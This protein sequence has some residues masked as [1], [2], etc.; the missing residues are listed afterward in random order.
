[1]I[2]HVTWRTFFFLGGGGGLLAAGF[3]AWSNQ[4][5]PSDDRLSLSLSLSL[6]F[7]L[8]SSPSP[9]FVFSIF[10]FL[11]FF[12]AIFFF[13]RFLGGQSQ[14]T[15]T[16]KKEPV[17]RGD[18]IGDA[19]DFTAATTGSS[20]RRNHW[21]E[22]CVFCWFV[23]FVKYSLSRMT[24]Q[25]QK[26]SVFQSSQWVVTPSPSPATKKISTQRYVS[27]SPMILVP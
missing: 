16:K 5:S 14:H 4:A 10:S 17:M 15:H 21:P 18:V 12:F 13:G 23:C 24:N 25:R 6:S 8:F 7:P 11:F 22:M 1:M 9:R 2:D 19:V 26:G 20:L 3:S 27:V